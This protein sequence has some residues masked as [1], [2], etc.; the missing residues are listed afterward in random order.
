MRIESI[1]KK[2]CLT[3]QKSKKNAE[4]SIKSMKIHSSLAKD[5]VLSKNAEKIPEKNIEK[6]IEKRSMAK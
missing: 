5:N 4:P 2:P 3:P 6:N 1:A